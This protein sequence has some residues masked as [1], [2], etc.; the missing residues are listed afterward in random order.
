LVQGLFELF[1]LT[2]LSLTPVFLA[3]GKN[4]PIIMYFGDNFFDELFANSPKIA[5]LFGCYLS[6]LM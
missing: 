2:P 3:L 1:D 4:S 6:Y 5:Y